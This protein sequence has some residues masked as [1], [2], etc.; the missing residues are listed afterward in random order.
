MSRLETLKRAHELAGLVLKDL[1]NLKTALDQWPKSYPED[2]SLLEGTDWQLMYIN[3]D[4]DIRSREPE[5]EKKQLEY[6]QLLCARIN[7]RIEQVEKSQGA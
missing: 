5:Y 2:R 3:N 7:E 6:L 4:A 1:A